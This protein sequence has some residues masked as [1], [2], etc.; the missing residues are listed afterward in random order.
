LALQDQQQRFLQAPLALLL[1]TLLLC[2]TALSHF[3]QAH[4]LQCLAGSLQD[5]PGGFLQ[6]SHHPAAAFLQGLLP[7]S[8]LL[9]LGL[10]KTSAAA[11]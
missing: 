4:F 5:L 3:L 9:L 1:Q 8:L 6:L 7:R 10:R 11:R 2:Y